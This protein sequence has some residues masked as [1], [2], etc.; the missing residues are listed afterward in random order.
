MG[1]AVTAAL[2]DGS[3]D[4]GGHHVPTVVGITLAGGAGALARYLLDGVISR[5]F[6]GFPWGTF[7]VNVSG[8]LLLGFLFIVLT[9]RL[10]VSP[11]V[12]STLTIGFLGGYTTFSTLSFETYRLIEDGAVGLA[13]A[14]A[15]GS[16]A[17]GIA[18]VYVGV[19]L[20]RLV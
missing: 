16:L 3:C 15:L 8:A 7:V 18:A 11:W 5:R 10:E 19:V 4:E 12:R 17:A 1:L 14:N 2:A 6:S 20:G 13:A 9:E